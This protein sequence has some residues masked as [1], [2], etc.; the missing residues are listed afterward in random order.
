MLQDTADK[1]QRG[2]AQMRVTVFVVEKV[3]GILKQLHMDVHAAAGF[4]P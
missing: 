4:P 1:P 2:V 3:A